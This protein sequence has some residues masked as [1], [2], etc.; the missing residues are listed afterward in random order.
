M[1]GEW[2]NASGQWHA[3][4]GGECLYGLRHLPRRLSRPDQC[5]VVATAPSEISIHPAGSIMNAEAHPNGTEAALP[6][7]PALHA[8]TLEFA[9]VEQLLTDIEVCT[10]LQEILPKYAAQGHV[11]ETGQ[12]T[13]AQARELLS[14]RAVRGLQL[15][16][17]YEGADWW[18]TVMVLGD[19]F[20]VVRIR[21]EFG[22]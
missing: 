22:G 21:H 20:R 11:P 16:Y 5:G 19:Q 1:S 10:E 8:T 17:R 18:D 4:G 2:R 9:Q 13:L 3:H 6:E 15:R 14:T 12:V 7:L